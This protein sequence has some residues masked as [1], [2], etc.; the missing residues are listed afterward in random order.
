MAKE[1]HHPVDQ[2]V[3]CFHEQ[4]GYVRLSFDM[5]SIALVKSPVRRVQGMR[6]WIRKY[7]FRDH[8]LIPCTC[9]TTE[10]WPT[11]FFDAEITLRTLYTI[12]LHK[13]RMIVTYHLILLRSIEC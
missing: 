12:P 1:L 10:T 9:R 6:R 11:E 7:L 2:H 4:L 5:G 13:S 3:R 8:S